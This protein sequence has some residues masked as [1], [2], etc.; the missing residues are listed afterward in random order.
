[1]GQPADTSS[2]GKPPFHIKT[3]PRRGQ[4]RQCSRSNSRIASGGNNG[5]R[6]EDELRTLIWQKRK[7]PRS[8]SRPGQG[9]NNASR[10]TYDEWKTLPVETLVRRRLLS[11]TLKQLELRCTSNTV[12]FVLD[13][14]HSKDA[15]LN[16]NE[17]RR[18][19]GRTPRFIPTPKRVDAADIAR[20]CDIVGYRLIKAFNRFACRKYIQHAKNH[21]IEGDS[22]PAYYHGI[23]ISFRIT[24]TSMN[25]TPEIFRRHKTLGI[26]LEDALYTMSEIAG[27]HCKL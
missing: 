4:H 26:Y 14:E 8:G 6:T 15:L 17:V 3:M 16:S 7:R 10:I 25:N 12:H 2:I 1:M 9:V 24:L 20:D 19:L 11:M 21:S 5:S 27:V 22:K 18:L 13:V 23:L